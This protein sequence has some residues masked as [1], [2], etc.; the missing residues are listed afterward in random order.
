MIFLF[1]Y[2]SVRYEP[3]KTFWADCFAKDCLRTERRTSLERFMSFRT[4]LTMVDSVSLGLERLAAPR[5]RRTDRMF[6]KPKS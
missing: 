2:K 4:L 5:V 3:K 6:R 1:I